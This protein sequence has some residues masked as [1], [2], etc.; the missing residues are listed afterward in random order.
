MEELTDNSIMPNGKHKGVKM[1]NVPDDYLLR[2]Y[3]DDT[4]LPAVKA[5]IKYNLDVLKHS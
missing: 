3:S 1:A 2:V 5:Y 4:C